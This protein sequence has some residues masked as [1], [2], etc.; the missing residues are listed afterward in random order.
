MGKSTF[1]DITNF[2]HQIEGMYSRI[3]KLYDDANQSVTPASN[4]LPDAFKEL[5]I[6]AEEL[7][8]ATE[9]LNQQNEQMLED[10]QKVATE[11]AY[12]QALFDCSPQAQLVTS[13]EGKIQ[14]A[15]QAAAR[16]L[17]VPTQLL[18]NKLLA[19][20]V[21]LNWRAGF[22]SQLNQLQQSH[23]LST[24]RIC[25]QTRDQELLDLLVSATKVRHVDQG[26]SLHWNLQE[27]TQLQALLAQPI[28]PATLPQVENPAQL[29]ENESILQKFS[30]QPYSKGEL[31]PL[32]PQKLWYVSQGL[33]KLS[34]FSANHE[35]VVLGLIGAGRPFSVGSPLL[36]T[37]Q[38]IALT[39]VQLISLSHAE[40]KAQPELT[41]LLLAKFQQ[42]LQQVE[43]LLNIAGQ[44]RVGDRLWHL[45]QLLRQEVGQPVAEGTVL[46]V[47][48]TH[49]DLASLCGTTRVTVTRL[50]GDLQRQNKIKLDRKHYILLQDGCASINKS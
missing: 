39:D 10:L 30:R 25:L 49:E 33:V 42:R 14:A 23:G 3:G 45:L 36:L 27:T 41:E 35:E 22:R 24:W 20:F 48:L 34:T 13:L 32:N 5:G 47:R 18:V 43:A 6:A 4:L 11:S 16:L 19:S 28:G 50:L 38:A 9:E 21:P 17:Q 15:N 29:D 46:S 44:R 37:Y 40:I 8:V 1:N 2:I 31:I 26:V 12:Y 7:Q